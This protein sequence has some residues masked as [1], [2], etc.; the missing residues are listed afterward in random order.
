MDN[1]SIVY[2]ALIK[3]GKPMKSAEIAS[4]TGL[5]KGE[6][7]KAIKALKVADKIVS[8]KMCFYSVR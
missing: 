4:V 5:E 6:V 1:Q 8:P 2:D 7:D 3:A